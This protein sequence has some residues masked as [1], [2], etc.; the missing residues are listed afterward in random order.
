MMCRSA[1]RNERVMALTQGPRLLQAS[2]ARTFLQEYF[3]GTPRALMALDNGVPGLKSFFFDP[4]VR[5]V[6]CRSVAARA[7]DGG[8]TVKADAP[9][10]SDKQASTNATAFIL[11][12]YRCNLYTVARTGKSGL[13]GRLND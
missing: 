10:S 11:L 2:I 8:V 9:H 6:M 12:L 1:A 5:T 4:Y 3:T 7:G 13:M